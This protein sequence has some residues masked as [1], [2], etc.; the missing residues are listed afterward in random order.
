M[1]L[2]TLG[3]IS[4]SPL[5]NFADDQTKL[6]KLRKDKMRLNK[7]IK[8][9]EKISK[10]S[11]CI[12]CPL[13]YTCANSVCCPCAFSYCLYKNGCFSC[14]KTQKMEDK[15]SDK[16]FQKERNPG[17]QNWRD[18]AIK[19]LDPCTCMCPNQNKSSDFSLPGERIDMK[20]NEK[21]IIEIESRW[22]TNNSIV[23]SLT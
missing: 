19:A 3:T 2:T 22:N 17:S 6:E 10:V 11:A 16:Q 18:I 8:K 12:C 23:V 14:P 1:T 4:V 13:V 21:Q 7:V 15:D 5:A 20:E 9:R